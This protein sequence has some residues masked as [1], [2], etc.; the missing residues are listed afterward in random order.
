MR[1][2]ICQGEEGGAGTA[3]RG[4]GA[5]SLR[6]SSGNTDVGGVLLP[7]TGAPWPTAQQCRK[8]RD[9]MANAQASV[10]Y[11]SRPRQCRMGLPG[12][13]PMECRRMA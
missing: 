7:E 1:T 6:R 11:V 13:G 3:R 2:D 12:V 4:G 9:K 8:E 5:A 10:R